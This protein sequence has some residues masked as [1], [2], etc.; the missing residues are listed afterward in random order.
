MKSTISL[1]QPSVKAS[2][3]DRLVDWLDRDNYVL[4]SIMEESVSN[5]QTLLI[6]NAMLSGCLLLCSTFV[7]IEALLFL[8]VWFA[9]AVLKCQKGGIK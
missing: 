1:H 8:F 4:S 3:S 5:R 9:W 7:C 2:L 6:A